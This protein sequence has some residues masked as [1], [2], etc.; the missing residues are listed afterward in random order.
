MYIFGVYKCVFSVVAVGLQPILCK[1][2]K[3]TIIQSFWFRQTQEATW[4]DDITNTKHSGAI[5]YSVDYSSTFNFFRLEL[6]CQTESS[7]S[8]AFYFIGKPC[9]EC[10]AIV[11][12]VPG[13]AAA[14]VSS[15]VVTQRT[16]A[17]L[18]WRTSWHVSS[19]EWTRCRTG[20]IVLCDELHEP[21]GRHLI[22][23]SVYESDCCLEVI[24]SKN[25]FFF[26]F[27]KTT[28]AITLNYFSSFM[29]GCNCLKDRE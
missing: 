20:H 3:Q 18:Q 24:F 25:I 13:A 7:S 16:A 26:S 8:C 11:K 9:L 14:C 1:G 15:R 6:F 29:K 27:N 23:Y 4:I 2:L 22:L 10:H 28:Q 17:A 12:A 19:V 21:I 5:I